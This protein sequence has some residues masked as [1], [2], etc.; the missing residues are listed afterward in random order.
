[1]KE[2]RKCG[3]AKPRSEFYRDSSKKDGLASHCKACSYTPKPKRKRKLCSIEACENPTGHRSGLCQKHYWQTPEGNAERK[4]Q[5]ART[6]VTKTCEWCGI[7]YR[8]GHP[9][10][11]ACT[12]RHGIWLRWNSPANS[13]ELVPVPRTRTHRPPV[14]AGN[15]V[16]RAWQVIISGNCSECG[17]QFTV[18]ASTTHT[19]GIPRYCAECPSKKNKWISRER[20]MSLYLRDKYECQICGLPVE[21][22]G[23]HPILGASLDHILPRSAGGSHASPNLRTVHRLCNSERGDAKL[24][25]PQVII[26][27]LPA[28]IEAMEGAWQTTGAR[29]AIDASD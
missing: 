20:R 23:T 1:M 3:E 11:R 12:Q 2:C 13:R 16:P 4:E 9:K 19:A 5:R 22:D 21:K 10:S 27:A 28:I 18:P 25:D 29:V 15:E 26:K 24:T 8:T 7:E 6:K 14:A 17:E